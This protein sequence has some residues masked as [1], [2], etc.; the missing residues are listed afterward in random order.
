MEAT[1]ATHEKVAQFDLTSWSKFIPKQ[2]VSL[3]NQERHYDAD[4]QD[5]GAIMAVHNMGTARFA[6]V[7][8]M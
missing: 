1:S 6:L 3:A 4:Y 8:L 5:C 7:L 2:Q